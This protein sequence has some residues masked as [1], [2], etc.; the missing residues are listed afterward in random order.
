ML[1][2]IDVADVQLGMYIHKL[3]GSWLKHPFWRTK[4]LLT[5]AQILADLR[6][7]DVEGVLIDVEK[8]DDITGS[9]SGDNGSGPRAPMPG[10]GER[11][12]GASIVDRA[13]MERL[14]VQP[15][16]PA[17][18]NVIPFNPRSTEP[19]STAREVGHAKA[20]VARASKILS[21]VFEQARLGKAISKGQ[22]E[23]II[24]D[25]F[26]SIQRNPHA[27]NGLMRIRR[28]NSSLYAHGLA[29]S[30]LMIALGR[31]MELGDER[32]KE[33]GLAGL[34]MDVGMGHLPIDVSTI[35]DDLSDIQRAIVETHTTLG[36]E[37]LTM[38]GEL[39]EEVRQVCL[40]HHERYDGSGYPRQL[41]GEEIGLFGRMAAICDVYDSY[42]SDRPHRPRIDPNAA[43]G[44]MR[45]QEGE[46]DD[47][48]L[49]QFIE[50]VGVYPIG[51]VVRLTTGRLALVVDQNIG[52]YTRPRVWS[53][54]DI[55]S[56]RVIKPED[57]DLSRCRG[58]VEIVCSDDA[59]EYG[60]ENFP[61]IRE[62]VFNSACK[63]LM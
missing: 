17:P 23:P 36:Y 3:E 47:D 46:F 28:E 13:R 12:R 1:K 54:Y 11:S 35:L 62:M 16:R 56:R 29:V 61:A 19:L 22:V 8:G 10:G 34:L 32:V 57:L 24:E 43:L 7:S 38:G 55:A 15:P 33:A 39:S 18:S 50:S 14:H 40:E 51:S 25:L 9:H 4:F 41:V 42:T 45:A 52:D 63:V 30:A 5:D 44:L 53:F 2:R 59:S 21:G 60:I 37:F 20:M 58:I 26:C 49:D 31:Q 6:A 48:I 27:F